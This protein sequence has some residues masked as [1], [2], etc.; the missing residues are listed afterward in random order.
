MVGGGAA[1]LIAAKRAAECGAQVTL[2]EKNDRLGMKIL[3]SGGGKC[4]LT[5]AGSMEEIRACFRPPEAR[6]LKPAFYRFTNDD[7]LSIL[8]ASG[9]QTYVRPDGRI[10]PIE[11]ANAKDVVA[12]LEEAVRA[13]GVRVVTGAAVSGLVVE[14]G[15]H[16]GS[17]RRGACAAGRTGYF[18]RRRLFLS[19]DGNDRRRLALGGGGR[20]HNGSVARR[21]RAALPG[22]CR[23]GLVRRGAARRNPPRPC[24][25]GRQGVYTLARR[26]ALHP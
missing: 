20:A 26:S 14:D 8:H 3:I 25:D 10:F 2:L 18:G 9:M 16:H 19:G 17:A 4:N 21:A 15:E 24:T 11:P 22:A 5:H 12:A 23:A 7:F 6:F 13:A 1:G